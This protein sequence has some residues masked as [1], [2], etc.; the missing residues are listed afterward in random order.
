MENTSYLRSETPVTYLQ[1]EEA[2]N[3]GSKCSYK[4]QASSQ[5]ST[6]SSTAFLTTEAS[7][8]IFDHDFHDRS[9]YW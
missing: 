6:H 8:L 3:I 7:I 2:P 9:R 4:S 5:V 1:L